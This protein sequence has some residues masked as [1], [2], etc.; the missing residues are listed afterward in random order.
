[1]WEDYSFLIASQRS[2]VYDSMDE[3]ISPNSSR[4]ASPFAHGKKARSS[5][6]SCSMTELSQQFGKHTLGSQRQPSHLRS[7]SND[8]HNVA[9]DRPA[10]AHNQNIVRRQ[11]QSMIR[12]QC[13]A[14]NIS[15]LSSLVQDLLEDDTWSYDTHITPLEDCDS[16]PPPQLDEIVPLQSPTFSSASTSSYSED[17]EFELHSSSRGQPKLKIGKEMKHSSSKEVM[18][19]QYRD[20]RIRKSVRRKSS[21]LGGRHG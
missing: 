17:G 13:S 1:M 14:A 21:I 16:L 5:K 12:R 6:N 11:R 8:P 15:R 2:I 3:S 18:G 19:R 7:P 10:P 20:I 9:R 4:G